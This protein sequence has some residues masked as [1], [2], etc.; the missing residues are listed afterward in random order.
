MIEQNKYISRHME[1]TLRRYAKLFRVVVLTGPRQSGKTTLAK[2]CFPEKTYVSLESPDVREFAFNDPKGFFNTLLQN[3]NGV[4]IDEA[5]LLPELFSYV[6]SIVDEE[7]RN[8]QF[9][10]TGSQNFSLLDKVSQSLAGRAGILNLLPFSLSELQQAKLSK[11]TLYEQLYYGGYPALLYWQDEPMVWYQSYIESYL[12][13]D[14]RHLLNVMDLNTY[15]TFVMLCASRC[16]QM[17]NLSNLGEDCGVAHNTAQRWISI[18][19]TSFL[20]HKL[21]PYYKSYGKRLVKTPKLY[22][23]DSGLLCAMLRIR[24]IE[25]LTYHSLRG[26]IFETWVIAEAIK[27]IANQGG[28]PELFFWRDKAGHEVDLVW[29]EG[30]KLHALET[31]SSETIKTEFAHGLRVLGDLVGSELK[32]KTLLYGGEENQRRSDYDL[33]S[34]RNIDQ[35]FLRKTAAID[36]AH[37]KRSS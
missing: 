9:I 23:L 28:R 30:E 6:Q 13:R 2:Q 17:L 14:L 34:W 11:K 31:K 33:L 8:G 4:I 29:Q 10:L 1:P 22:F 24:S 36:V 12:E 3:K 27:C 32:S 16:G 18:L 26:S 37:S 7:K 25:E 15:R 19:E 21:R 20:A 35:L 5:Q